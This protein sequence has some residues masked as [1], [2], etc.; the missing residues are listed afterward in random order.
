MQQLLDKIVRELRVRNYSPRT[1]KAYCYCVKKYLVFVK[2]KK[3]VSANEAIR[4]YILLRQSE[5]DS[6]RSINQAIQAIKFFYREIIKKPQD[7][8]IKYQK[9]ERSL[10]VV[11][12]KKEVQRI[13]SSIKNEKHRLLVSIAYGSGLRVSEVVEMRV[14][15]IDFDRNVI[16]VKKGKGMKDR[17]TLLPNKI[18]A[19]LMAFVKGIKPDEYIFRSQTGGRLQVRTAQ[20]IFELACKK[21]GI[22]KEASFHSLR[23]SFATH[24]IESGVDIR[25]VQAL[26]GHNDIRTTEQY[27]HISTYSISGITSPL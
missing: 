3:F 22:T 18:S 8:D 15:H 25:F 12:S 10:P 17:L 1:I 21:A 14:V 4:E 7:I 11:L 9:K 5:T 19:Q 24:L 2:D 23:H 16:L 6:Y 26:L 20:K 13:I 27:T